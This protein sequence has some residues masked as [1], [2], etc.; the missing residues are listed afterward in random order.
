MTS[1]DLRTA[2]ESAPSK[3]AL[4]GAAKRFVDAEGKTTQALSPVDLEVRDGEFVCLVGPSGCGKSTVLNLVA[5]LDQASE[6]EVL[7]RGEPVRGPGPDRTVMFQEAALFPWLTVAENVRFPLDVAG[8]AR[9]EASGR[10]EQYLR[11]VHLWKFR[12]ARPH[13]LSGGMRQRAALARSL[14]VE[15][16][17]LLMDEPFGA[18]DAQTCEMLHAELETIWQRTK[19]TVL[20]VTHNVRE[21]VRLADRV[22][23]M[24]T[25]PGRIKRVLEVD[26]PRPRDQEQRDVGLLASVLRAELKVEIE[27]VLREEVDDGWRPTQGPVRPGPDRGMGGGI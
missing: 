23:V 21:A 25:R 7:V 24:G 19:K 26:L 9:S 27:K 15:P 5:G 1:R 12:D 6:G 3:I 18:L 8:V 17:I 13:E 16:D 11:M 22:V 14:V 2:H 4:R 20:F 10:V